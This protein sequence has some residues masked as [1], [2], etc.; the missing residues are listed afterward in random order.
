MEFKTTD[1]LKAGDIV[2]RVGTYGRRIDITEVDVTPTDRP[3]PA[4]KYRWIRVKDRNHPA[5]SSDYAVLR[6][7]KWRVL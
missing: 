7:S 1:E 5:G 2:C 6:D 3:L 4:D